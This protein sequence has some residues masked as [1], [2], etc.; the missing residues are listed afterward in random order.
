M[1]VELVVD[2]A[3]LVAAAGSLRASGEATSAAAARIRSADA[4]SEPSMAAGVAAVVGAWGGVAE[5]L[6][7]T[8][9]VLAILVERAAAGYVATDGVIRDGVAAR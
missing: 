7:S 9:G 8:T 5:M 2:P 6:A 1:S 4:P 3:A